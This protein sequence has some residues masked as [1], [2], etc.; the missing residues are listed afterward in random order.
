MAG[1]RPRRRRPA[2]ARR[3]AVAGRARRGRIRRRRC[4]GRLG[5]GGPSDAG[6][7]W[8]RG[9]PLTVPMHSRFARDVA[10]P[11]EDLRARR[12]ALPRRRVRR[13]RWP[14]RRS[15][16]LRHDHGRRRAVLEDRA[17]ASRLD[18]LD[19]RAEVH[20]LG[21]A[22]A[23]RVLWHRAH[24]RRADDPGQD[25]GTAGRGV[26]GGARPR[27]CR[28]RDADDRVDQPPRP[29]RALHLPVRRRDQGGQRPARAGPV[30]A[31]RRPGVLEQVHDAGVDAVGIHIETFDPTCSRSWRPAR[32]SAGS[33]GTSAAG[34]GPSR[35]SGAGACR[36]T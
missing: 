3:A 13:T 5:G 11:A 28:R 12:P 34:S 14:S 17:P 23:V 36:P 1:A 22:R 25:P 18:R 24:A 10:V 16:D 26:H 27:R 35:S 30:R 21:H 8:V 7:L 29:R 4:P 2:A 15:P 9:L 19:R 32:R 31:A 33:R 6:F 20:L